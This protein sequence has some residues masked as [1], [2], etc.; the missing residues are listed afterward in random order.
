MGQVGKEKIGWF[1][2][3]K[4][5]TPILRLVS[6]MTSLVGSSEYLE[7]SSFLGNFSCSSF[8]APLFL[9]SNLFFNS[10]LSC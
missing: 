10:K 9:L 8:L 7:V 2:R 5:V 4:F 3:Q 1:H 6:C